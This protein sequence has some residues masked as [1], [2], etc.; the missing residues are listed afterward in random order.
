MILSSYFRVK[1]LLNSITFLWKLHNHHHMFILHF[2]YIPSYLKYNLLAPN[3]SWNDHVTINPFRENTIK[4]KNL[5]SSVPTTL[6]FLESYTF[7]LGL[8]STLLKMHQPTTRRMKERANI[9]NFE[10]F[11]ERSLKG[12][13]KVPLSPPESDNSYLCKSCSWY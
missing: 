7:A 13:F 8:F 4:T 2:C 12:G 10:K 5:K 9:L 6:L 3:F 1:W 11:P